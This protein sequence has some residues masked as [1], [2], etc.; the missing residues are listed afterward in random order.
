MKS[1]ISILTIAA[2][3]LVSCASKVKTIKPETVLTSIIFKDVYHGNAVSGAN[4]VRIIKDSAH[5]DGE[6]VTHQA[7]TQ[8]YA[9][10]TF[11]VPDPK[12]STHKLNLKTHDGKSDSLTIAY[13]P[14]PKLDANGRPNILLDFQNTSPIP[15]APQA[16]IKAK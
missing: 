3:F 7:D 5:I 1:I 12:D 4:A 13:P 10:I 6:R 14:I 2:F 11:T 15:S 9:P 16:T 8:Y